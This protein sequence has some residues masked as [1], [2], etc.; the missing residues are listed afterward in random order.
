MY[1]ICILLLAAVSAML[2]Y[3]SVCYLI[4]RKSNMKKAEGSYE[5]FAKSELNYLTGQDNLG[6]PMQLIEFS[7]L[8]QDK[9]QEQNK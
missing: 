1:I 2:S 3:S 4:V 7:K 9:E 8:Y 5:Q 6:Y